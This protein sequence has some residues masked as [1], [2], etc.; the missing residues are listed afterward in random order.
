MAAR[1]NTS[2]LP[3]R[4]AV[5][6]LAGHRCLPRSEWRPFDARVSSRP[7]C[8][9]VQAQAPRGSCFG[10]LLG[11]G[12]APPSAGWAA[13]APSLAFLNSYPTGLEGTV[14]SYQ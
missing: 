6:R 11:G 3:A 5:G 4:L 8:A 9:R 13:S 14:F 1:A 12:Q 2:R 10:G 7:S